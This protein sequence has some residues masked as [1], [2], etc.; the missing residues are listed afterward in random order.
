MTFIQEEIDKL[1]ENGMIQPSQSAWSSPVVVVNKKN[2]SKRLCI[3]YRELNK[4]TK[5]DGWPIPRIDEIL[6]GLN[7]ASWFTALDLRCGY[8]Q[9]PIAKEDMEKTAFIFDRKSYEFKVMPFGLCNAPATCQRTMTTVFD[10]VLKKFVM[11]YLDDVIVYSRSFEEHITHVNEVFQRLSKANLRLNKEKCI[12]FRRELPFLGH[13]VNEK[14]ILMDP[15]KVEAVRNMPAPKNIRQLRAFIG[16]VSYYRK[17]IKDFARI[18]APLHELTKKS[19]RFVWAIDQQHAFEELKHC[20][21]SKP[22]LLDYPNFESKFIVTTDA[23]NVALGA[24]LSQMVDGEEHPIC[25]LS[26]VLNK[27]ER[28]YSTTERE[29]LAVIFAIKQLKYY[30][31]ERKFELRTDH[32]SL[33]S[34]VGKQDELEGK[35]ARWAMKL[36][37]FDY[38]IVHKPGK[39]NI[40]AD[41]LSIQITVSDDESQPVETEKVDKNKNESVNNKNKPNNVG[42][43][44][45]ALDSDAKML[46]KENELRKEVGKPKVK[47]QDFYKKKHNGKFV[48]VLSSREEIEEAMKQAHDGRS[49]FGI[50]SVFNYLN[51][52]VWWPTMFQDIKEWI[53]SCQECQLY[54]PIKRVK[55]EG[56]IEVGEIFDRFGFDFIGP[57][58]ESKKGSKYI[59]VAT[60]Y[61][62][63]WPIARAVPVANAETVATFIYEEIIY[64]YGCPKTILTDQGTHF[65]NKLVDS[66]CEIMKSKHHVSSPYH[67]QT[68]GL[69]R[70]IQWNLN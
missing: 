47:D 37:E 15:K 5:K 10:D 51:D 14:G 68:N 26:R 52:R 55:A 1:L 40:V 62:T 20:I 56:H 33:L 65:R 53:K 29:C 34:I 12:F 50:N 59:L 54:K 2:G 18:A 30:L 16:L 45:I 22:V 43:T 7:G 8:W 66:L 48:K 64:N 38:D 44:N 27:A 4:V 42:K 17:F 36:R 9:I 70:T 67:P 24:V 61:L 23:S 11:V 46:S 57:M 41:A 69:T 63:K 28:N 19:I 58:T 25:Y 3:D 13:I 31:L 32:K 60:E 35:L 6:E 49:H 39:E 21:T